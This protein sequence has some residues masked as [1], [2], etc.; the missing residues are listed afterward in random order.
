VIRIVLADDQTLLREGLRAIL[1]AQPDLEVVGEAADGAEAAVLARRHS[2]DVVVMDVRMAPVDGIE[3]TRRVMVAGSSRVLVLTT[4]DL[5]DYVVAALEAGA[6]GF[7]LKDAPREQ[8]LSAIRAVAAGDLALA[9]AVTR[10]LVQAHLQ[11]RPA[12]ATP[13][14]VGALSRREYEVFVLMA[15]GLANA[16]IAAALVVSVP[17]V[18]RTWRAS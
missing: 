1:D 7:V 13:G 12:A 18:R 10:R 4:F 8:L 14:R 15:Q 17:T 3:G 6:S 2:P 5:D 11:R 9:P 16:E